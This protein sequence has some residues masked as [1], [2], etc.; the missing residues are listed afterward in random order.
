MEINEVSPYQ[1]MLENFADNQIREIWQGI[2]PFNEPLFC[3]ICNFLSKSGL[4]HEPLSYA[5]PLMYTRVRGNAG[6][7]ACSRDSYF[8]LLRME[9]PIYNSHANNFTVISELQSISALLL[10]TPILD[11]E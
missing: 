4:C 9:A 3:F 6:G 2:T 7:Q 10:V 8:E 11:W 1:N 5:L